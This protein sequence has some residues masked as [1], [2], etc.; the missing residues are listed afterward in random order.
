MHS[1]NTLPKFNSQFKSACSSCLH[2][3]HQSCCCSL[4]W[5]RNI[6]WFYMS[7]ISARLSKTMVCQL[8]IKVLTLRN[9]LSMLHMLEYH[10]VQDIEYKF[11]ML[12]ILTPQE[13]VPKSFKFCIIFV[14]FVI[15]FNQTIVPIPLI[16]PLLRNHF[17]ANCALCSGNLQTWNSL[18]SVVV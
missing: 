15:T 10:L 13:D 7:N 11:C 1:S 4:L 6:T 5:R 12:T 9:I 17:W 2:T 8:C 14:I 16:Y 3:T 18:H